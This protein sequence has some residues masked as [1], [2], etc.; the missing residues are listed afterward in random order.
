M[1]KFLFTVIIVS[2]VNILP[3]AAKP[4]LIFHPRMIFILIAALSM[5][6]TQPLFTFKETTDNK[7]TDRFSVLLILIAS[8][9]SIVWAEAEWAYI[10]NSQSN[11]IIL[12]VTGIILIVTGIALRIWAIITLGNHFTV[13]VRLNQEHRIIANGPY[14]I[15]RHPSYSGAF[16]A[17]TGSAFFLNAKSAIFI[18][19]IA[20]IIAYYFRIKSEEKL[21]T[22]H[23]GNEY[24]KYAKNK[25][26]LIPFI[27]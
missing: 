3:L 8:F 19:I 11:N 4:E 17:I 7:T 6:L 20:M 13:T 22:D 25:K 24:T 2:I 27:W 1:Y 10:N 23:F 21:L 26:R 5:W 18:S 9:T 14:A 16:F 15:L 12:T